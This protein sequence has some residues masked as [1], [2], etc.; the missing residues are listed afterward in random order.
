MEA[1]VKV[2][3]HVFVEGL[4]YYEV[5][6]LF[7]H[8]VLASSER[9]PWQHLWLTLTREGWIVRGHPERKPVTF[10]P[11][12]RYVPVP[13]LPME[14]LVSI[15]KELDAPTLLSFCQVNR[16]FAEL[17][18]DRYFWREKY[19]KDFGEPVSEPGDWKMAYKN[20]YL[21]EVSGKVYLF[22]HMHEDTMPI[23]RPRPVPY[24][25]GK[26]I[27]SSEPLVAILDTKGLI[28]ILGGHHPADPFGLEVGVLHPPDFFQLTAPEA[29]DIAGGSLHLVIQAT[30]GTVWTLGDN[31][32]GQLGLGYDVEHAAGP[33]I[34][35]GLT[36]KQIAAGAYHT[37]V[38]DTNNDLYVFGANNK[39][40]LG[41]GDDNDR[42]TPTLIPH[43][44]FKS[45]AAGD[46]H[47]VALDLS[48][49]V[50]VFGSNERLQLSS[51]FGAS[52]FLPSPLGMTARYIAAGNDHTIII[53]LEGNVW[54]SGQDQEGELGRGAGAVGLG[55]IE[56]F[57]AKAA[58]G[59]SSHSLFLGMNNRVLVCGSNTYGQLGIPTIS[60]SD[61]PIEIHGLEGK[62]IF[63][64][65]FLSGV[66]G[67]EI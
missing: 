38:I 36:A 56:G 1:G 53:D 21:L 39:G 10:I 63:A 24:I 66:I 29:V 67:R 25:K 62:L 50:L 19:I 46:A 60:R 52:V 17:C 31:G 11:K 34:I 15:A 41:L 49:N 2:G 59:G 16:E 30:D 26:A 42:F 40:Q 64:S 12:E 28:W 45:V 3:D 61:H 23:R 4:G 37:L 44:K 65:D 54:T 20:A 13:H 27:A 32:D 5:Q 47:T 22:G 33:R 14:L 51:L 58:A 43:L 18:N 6:L 9:Y 7:D 48:G 8:S 57:K 35:P 55:K